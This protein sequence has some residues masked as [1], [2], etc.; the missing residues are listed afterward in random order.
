MRRRFYTIMILAIMLQGLLAGCG[1]KGAV[2]KS[3]LIP[4]KLVKIAPMD[5]DL[6]LEYVG[7]I[8]A[9]DEVLVYPRVGG[10]I[11]EK[12]KKDGDPIAKGETIALIDRDEVG[13]KFEKSPVES[14]LDG[15]VGRIYVDIGTVVT[16][17]TAVALVVNMSTVKIKL[18]IPERHIP[19][20]FLDQEAHISVDAYPDEIFIGKVTKVSPVVDIATRTAPIE[21]TI[22][23]ADYRLKSGMFAK[24][25]LIIE[26]HKNALAVLKEALIG[27][28]P[29]ISV[30]AVSGGQASLR[31]VKT[32]IRQ[33]P[34]VEILEGLSEGDEVVVMG[35]QKLY[36]GAPV[37]PQE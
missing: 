26:E 10:K 3:D 13:F 29:D 2:K 33:G 31:K 19:K 35:Q 1:E 6:A 34:Y 16:P 23:N 27:T 17:Q 9:Q 8:K 32:G 18:G 24:V 30:Y 5:M 15:V 22:D 28:E 7:D 4:V 25:K 14:F 37:A 11:V 21:I 36:E 20:V 12:L